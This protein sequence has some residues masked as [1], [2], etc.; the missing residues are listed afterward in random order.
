M[1][2]EFNCFVN[3]GQLAVIGAVIPL[4]GENFLE[5][6][7]NDAQV[8]TTFYSRVTPIEK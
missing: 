8:S 1:Q 3:H 7:I 2:E 4:C 6:K 5:K